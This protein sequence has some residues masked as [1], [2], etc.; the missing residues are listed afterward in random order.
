MNDV[1]AACP[2]Y[3]EKLV[4][5]RKTVM[6]DAPELL[7]CYSDEKSVPLFN[8]DNCNG[9]DFYYT[10]LD[11]LKQT[12]ELWEYSYINRRFV[13][14]TVVCN[15][16]GGPVGTIECFGRPMDTGKGG[17]ALLRIDLRSD[18]ETEPVLTEILGIAGEN[19]YGA[20]GA[21]IILTKAVPAASERIAALQNAGYRPLGRKLGVYDDYYVREKA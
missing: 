5:L 21:D 8:S 4:T 2:V 19:F 6:G 9:D 1:Y 16:S 3:R 18:F 14:W 7:K 20:F 17:M 15:S 11:R 13:R 10:T 12:M